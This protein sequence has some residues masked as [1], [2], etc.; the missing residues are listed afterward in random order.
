MDKEYILRDLGVLY[1]EMYDDEEL[2]CVVSCTYIMDKLRPILDALEADVKL[3]KEI[4]R[5][6]QKLKEINAK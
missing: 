5:A 3:E 4:A 6:Y 1:R 2:E